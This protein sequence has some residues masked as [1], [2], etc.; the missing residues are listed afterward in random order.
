MP[1]TEEKK[2]LLRSIRAD[3][4]LLAHLCLVPFIVVLKAMVAGLDQVI[5]E[6]TKV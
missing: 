5:D 3:L 2:T 4:R 1:D 6:L